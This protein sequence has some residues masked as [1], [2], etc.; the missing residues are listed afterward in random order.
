MEEAFNA[1]KGFIEEKLPE[2]LAELED[3]EVP[4]PPPSKIVF[5]VVDLSRT[6]GKVTCVIVPGRTEEDGEGSLTAGSLSNTLTVGFVC[7]K[8]EY[9]T[10]LK[11][12]VRYAKAFRVAVRS[13]WS[14]GGRVDR[15]DLGATEFYPDAGATS[16]S[17]TIAETEITVLTTEANADE[18]DPFD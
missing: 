7:R 4:L 13:D 5:G 3:G 14:L 18:V 9:Q 6:E 2:R 1:L 10:L 8:S 17:C 11:Q 16:G 15:A 12:M